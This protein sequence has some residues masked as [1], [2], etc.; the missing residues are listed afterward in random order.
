[1][2]EEKRME[3]HLEKITEKE[4]K[5][6][7]DQNALGFGRHFTDHMLVIPYT[8]GREIGRASCRERV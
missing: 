6:K 2:F 3:L 7:P 4:A 5:P 1:M 8:E